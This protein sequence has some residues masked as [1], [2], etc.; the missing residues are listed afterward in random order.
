[1][2]W[3]GVATIGLSAIL[4]TACQAG[5]TPTPASAPVCGYEVIASYPHDPNSYTQGLALDDERLF[6]GTGIRGRSTVR[7]VDVVSGRVVRSVAIP[8]EH[9]GEG[10]TIVDDRLYQLTWQSGKGFVYDVSSFARVDE[11]AYEGEGWGLTYDGQDLIM[12]DGTARLRFLEPETYLVARTLDVRADGEPVERLNELEYVNGEILANVWQTDDI[13]RIDPD[14]GNV[15]AW[16]D[17]TGL[18]APADRSDSAEVLNGIAYD[19]NA[20]RLFV[21]GKLWPRLY[22]IRLAQAAGQ[23]ACPTLGAARS[24]AQPS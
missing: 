23:G 20:D 17:L 2:R 5:V 14:T 3:H 9:F 11:F 1:M 8:D 4:A 24:R 19:M 13:A 15:I 21:T 10:I 18:P 7:E 12:S 22:E 16:I 6:E